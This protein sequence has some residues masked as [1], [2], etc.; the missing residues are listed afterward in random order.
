M[1]EADT[2]SLVQEAIKGEDSITAIS[3]TPSAKLIDDVAI[4]NESPSKVEGPK[5]LQLSPKTLE[6]KLRRKCLL[7]YMSCRLTNK[8]KSCP[9][10]EW[11]G[12]G[13]VLE[14]KNGDG[15]DKESAQRTGEDLTYD[16]WVSR[17]K[18]EEDLVVSIALAP[19]FA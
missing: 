12:G 9:L 7:P 10:R 16:S 17:P 2:P 3:E 14:I 18:E 5:L 11:K 15:D 8:A 4:N 6:L 13:L 1:S 19:S